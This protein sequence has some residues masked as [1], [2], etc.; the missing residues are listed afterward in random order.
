[1]KRIFFGSLFVF[2][3][4]LA[5]CGGAEEKKQMDSVAPDSSKGELAYI[6]PCGRCPEVREK[7]AGKCPK[8]EMDLVEEK[9]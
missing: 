8:C 6:C 2:A 5:A 9:K 7:A 1:M 4:A 3:V